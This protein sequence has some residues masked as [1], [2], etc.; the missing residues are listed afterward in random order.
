M[1]NKGNVY[2]GVNAVDTAIVERV[3]MSIGKLKVELSC[4][5][6]ISH[7]GLRPKT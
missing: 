2:V 7:E 6:S 1:L 3:W 5:S 4:N